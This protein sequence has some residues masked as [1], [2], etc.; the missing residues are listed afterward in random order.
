MNRFFVTI[1]RIQVRNVNALPAWW[2]VAPPGPFAYLGFAHALARECCEGITPEVAIVHHDFS[3]QAL[4]NPKGKDF[5]VH[6]HQ[7]RGSSL[8]N[9]K[10]Y[11]KG[12]KSLSLQPTV[13]GDLTVTLV[14]AFPEDAPLDMDA[15]KS[16]MQQARVA[17]GSV[18][19]HGCIQS[20]VKTMKEAMASV[21]SGFLIEERLDILAA[22][23]GDAQG[24]S[25]S[26]LERFMD[27]T[28]PPALRR[29]LS[30]EQP[31]K[32]AQKVT[33]KKS[34]MTAL[35]AVAEVAEELTVDEGVDDLVDQNVTV[36]PIA[37][38][39]EEGAETPVKNQGWLIPTCLGFAALTNTSDRAM[40]RDGYQHAYAEPLVGVVEYRSLRAINADDQPAGLSFW[41]YGQPAGHSDV[42][43]AT[44]S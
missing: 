29:V 26:I 33:P 11:A 22:P 20:P 32:P 7:F 31:W 44:Q 41:R 30:G 15:L 6:P 2:F 18:V 40:T 24:A 3:L 10:D 43:V 1:P 36:D 19:D 14:L 37:I 25:F 8:I 34:K 21:K 38:Q 35:P 39:V 42:F 4:V 12:T 16:F 13:R 17:G 9:E 5:Q 27:V 23:E 28:T